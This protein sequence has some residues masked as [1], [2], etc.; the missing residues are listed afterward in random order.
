MSRRLGL[1]HERYHEDPVIPAIAQPRVRLSCSLRPVW[2]S[3]GI[4]C[5]QSRT[6]RGACR[7]HLSRSS[8]DRLPFLAV[9]LVSGSLRAHLRIDCTTA[10]FRATPSQTSGCRSLV[11]CSLS[12][13]SCDCD[14]TRTHDISST[15]VELASEGSA[16]DLTRNDFCQLQG[17]RNKRSPSPLD[18]S[19]LAEQATHRSSISIKRTHGTDC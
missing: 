8:G 10:G 5:R 2:S 16:F 7:R 18:L 19:A 9:R 15:P 1:Q 12:L 13:C 17:Y 11:P 14:S 4:S 6:C 3:R